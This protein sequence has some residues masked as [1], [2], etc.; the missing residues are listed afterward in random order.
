MKIKKK[1]FLT[2]R[3]LRNHWSYWCSFRAVNVEKQVVQLEVILRNRESIKSIVHLRTCSVHPY[4]YYEVKSNKV[5]T[6]YWL[7][8]LFTWWTVCQGCSDYHFSSNVI[9][10]KT[11]DLNNVTCIATAIT[12]SAV[13]AYFFAQL[14]VQSAFALTASI[15]HEIGWNYG[16]FVAPFRYH[17][18]RYVV[19]PYGSVYC[20]WIGILSCNNI[21][22]KMNC[23]S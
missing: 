18:N 8:T 7:L 11:V 5:W 2:L 12:V 15:N 10:F 13:V 14:I 1:C 17:D 3:I 21:Y 16:Y 19:A 6:Q 22:N 4:S 9:D 23:H 20:H